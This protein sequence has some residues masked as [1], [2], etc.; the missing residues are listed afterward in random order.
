M[1]ATNFQT[2]LLKFFGDTFVYSRFNDSR[3][4]SDLQLHFVFTGGLKKYHI[5]TVIMARFF[6]NFDYKMSTRI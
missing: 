4:L 6:I 1:C 5:K 3:C 2:E